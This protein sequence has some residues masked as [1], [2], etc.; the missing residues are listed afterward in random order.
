VC[1]PSGIQII[2]FE[3]VEDRHFEAPEDAVREFWR[4]FPNAFENV[5]DLRLGNAQQTR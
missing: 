2:D 4:E 5:V 1:S 3:Q